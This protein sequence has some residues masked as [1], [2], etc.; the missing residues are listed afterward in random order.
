MFAGREMKKNSQR[1][2]RPR[3]PPGLAASQ[4]G[5]VRP[6]QEREERKVG[7]ATGTPADTFD[8]T[9]ER[10]HDKWVAIYIS[11]LAVLIAITLT[12]S[13]DAMKTAQQA[14]IQVNDNYAF[15]QA[16]LIRQSRL[17]IASDQFEI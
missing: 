1:K 6:E 12:G 7:I 17:K 5:A 4:G 9:S 11:V 2:P 13:N 3:V 8:E 15:Y 16:K 14:S 10:K